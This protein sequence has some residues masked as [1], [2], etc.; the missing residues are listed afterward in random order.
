MKYESQYV[1]LKLRNELPE[2]ELKRNMD[3]GVV[4]NLL[5]KHKLLPFLYEEI[6]E[7]VPAE[8]SQLFKSK[9]EENIDKQQNLW[10]LFLNIIQ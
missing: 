6:I 5:I 1:L 3:W 2:E 10:K 4:L 9:L 8:Y 7:D